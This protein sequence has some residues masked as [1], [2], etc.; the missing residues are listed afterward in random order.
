MTDFLNDPHGNNSSTRLVMFLW[1]LAV[2]LVW[3]A[4]CFYKKDIVDI[5]VGV[6]GVLLITLGGKVAQSVFGE[7]G[8]QDDKPD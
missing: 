4:V 3:V 2:M 8:K 1:S 6:G 5:P 7:N